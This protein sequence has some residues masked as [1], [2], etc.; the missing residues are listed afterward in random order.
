[1]ISDTLKQGDSERSVKYSPRGI[2]TPQSPD[3]KAH[4]QPLVQ[5][6][7]QESMLKILIAQIQRSEKAIS[8]HAKEP[9][10]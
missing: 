8:S 6:C 5:L 10:L 3:Y 9:F 4:S 7:F 2:R 1:M